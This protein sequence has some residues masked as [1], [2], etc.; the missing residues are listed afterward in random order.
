M[1]DFT[2]PADALIVGGSMG[3]DV[4]RAPASSCGWASNSTSKFVQNMFFKWPAIESAIKWRQPSP[5]ELSLGAADAS[6]SKPFSRSAPPGKLFSPSQ[7][8]SHLCEGISTPESSDS[9]CVYAWSGQ[10]IAYLN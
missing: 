5:I 9:A 7:G 4:R 1:M 6:L 8:C 2:V 3:L 10:A